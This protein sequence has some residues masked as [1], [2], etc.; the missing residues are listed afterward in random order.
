M[1]GKESARIGILPRMNRDFPYPTLLKR[2]RHSTGAL[3]G[4]VTRMPLKCQH[5]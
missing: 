3:P 4:R 1:I 2:W 5:L